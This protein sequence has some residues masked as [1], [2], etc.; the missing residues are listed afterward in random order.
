V[1]RW[2]EKE[3]SKPEIVIVKDISRREREK[4]REGLS[5]TQREVE[6]GRSNSNVRPYGL[7]FLKAKLRYWDVHKLPSCQSW[8]PT[9]P[10]RGY[11]I[12]Q[13]AT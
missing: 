11:G 2:K 6:G 9:A 4:K 7:C 10:R 3:R 5:G 1:L 12:G 13:A 8:H